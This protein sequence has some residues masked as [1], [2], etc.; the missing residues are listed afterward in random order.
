MKPLISCFYCL[1]DDRAPF[2]QVV[3]LW[4]LEH[5]TKR[6]TNIQTMVNAGGVRWKVDA[7]DES[8]PSGSS[9]AG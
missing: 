8:L 7:N 9:G 2:W 3:H 6:G 1:W 5:L 4:V